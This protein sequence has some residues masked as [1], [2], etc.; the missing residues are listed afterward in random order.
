[1][2]LR[3]P[4]HGIHPAEPLAE[5]RAVLNPASTW[6]A[7]A[8]GGQRAAAAVR[9]LRVC[10]DKSSPTCSFAPVWFFRQDGV[11]PNPTTLTESLPPTILC[12]RGWGWS[13]TIFFSIRVRAPLYGKH[14]PSGSHEAEGPSY[15]RRVR[16]C[17]RLEQLRRVW[18]KSGAEMSR[19][20]RRQSR[21]LLVFGFPQTSCH[22]PS[23]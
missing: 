15:A 9:G 21:C 10:L 4:T 6:S 17:A 11:L 1:M 16:A 13:K 5:L 19:G 18:R 23:P 3:L 7:E 14:R 2:W 20:M 8:L 12:M 22:S